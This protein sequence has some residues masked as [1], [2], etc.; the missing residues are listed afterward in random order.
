VSEH[1]TFDGDGYPTEET[2]DAIAAWDWHD[3]PAL[4]EYVAAAWKWDML[5]N[6]PSKIEPA[7]NGEDDGFYWCGATGGW[8]GNEDLVAALGR[9]DMFMALCWSASVRGGYHEFHVVPFEAK[10]GE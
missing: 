9:N 5:K 8:S 7:L 6:E 3:F 10:E 4:M 2:L 1:P